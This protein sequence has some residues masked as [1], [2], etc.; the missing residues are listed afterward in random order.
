MELEI[1]G[2]T[3]VQPFFLVGL[4]QVDVVLGYGW[5][6]ELGDICADFQE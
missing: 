1:Q 5:I 3:I 4:G 6:A 2:V